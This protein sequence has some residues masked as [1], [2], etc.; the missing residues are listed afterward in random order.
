MSGRETNTSWLESFK[1]WKSK[2]V[3]FAI[4]LRLWNKHFWLQ[5]FQSLTC[6]C[7]SSIIMT[8]LSP[9]FHHPPMPMP[10][11]GLTWPNIEACVP[12]CSWRQ[13]NCPA[14][15]DYGQI[16]KYQFL[17]RQEH[18]YTGYIL[19]GNMNSA[20]LILLCG[21]LACIGQGERLAKCKNHRWCCMD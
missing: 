7:V 8:F 4:I 5:S 14:Y 6:V 9:L 2:S 21:V 10:G 1:F 3:G 18:R 17:V 16:H 13:H 12:R 19:T 20:R 11:Y 15:K